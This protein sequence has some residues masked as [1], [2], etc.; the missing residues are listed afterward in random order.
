M[1]LHRYLIAMLHLWT[2]TLRALLMFHMLVLIVLA[3]HVEIACLNLMM[4]CFLCLVTM[5]KCIYF[6]EL[7]C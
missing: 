5:I 2:L 1:I 7:L 6:L 3:Y 4:I